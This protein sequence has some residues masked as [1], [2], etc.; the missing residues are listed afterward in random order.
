[1]FALLRV[2]PLGA[3]T[4]EAP[5]A[6]EPRPDP[7]AVEQA[8][9]ALKTGDWILKWEAMSQLARWKCKDAAGALKAILTGQDHPWVRGRALVALADL[10]GEEMLDQALAVSSNPSP[11][12][13]GAAADALGAIGSLRGEPAIVERLKDGDASVRHR[14]LV[15]FARLRGAAAWDTIAPR[16]ADPDPAV[17]RH[18]TQALVYIPTPAALGKMIELLAHKDKSVRIEASVSL[19]K[20]RAADAIPVLL[21]HM[22]KDGETDVRVACQTALAS[23]PPDVLAPPLVN[24]LRTEDVHL[25][26]AALKLLTLQPTLEAC[27]QVAALVRVPS[28]DYL[29]VLDDAFDLLASIQPDRYRSIFVLYLIHERADIRKRAIEALARCREGDLF[30]LLRGSL[31]DKEL[32]VRQA[33]F[34]ALRRCTQGAPREGIVDYL[35]PALQSK[36]GWTYQ[37]AIRLLGERITL[38]DLPKGLA[39]LDAFLGGSDTELRKLAAKALSQ[40]GPDES[41]REVARAQGFL[42]DWHLLGPFPNEAGRGFHVPYPPEQEVDLQ[43][44]YDGYFLSYGAAFGVTEAPCGGVRKRSLA[45]HPPWKDDA[46]GQVAATFLLDLPAAQELKL[47]MSLGL[48]DKA[49]ASDGAQLALSVD[50]AKLFE[51]VAR[52]DAWQP[53]EI[54]LSAYAGKKVALDLVAEPL[55]GPADDAVLVGEPKIVAGEKTVADLLALAPAALPR[56]VIPGK[57]QPLAWQPWRVN[58]IDGLVPLHDIFPPPTNQRLAYAVADLDS[59]DERT[60]RLWLDTD[61]GFILW[62]NGAKVAER[63][64]AG[65]Q[66][67][68]LKLRPGRNRLLIKVCN[69][70]DWWQFS[71]R[72]TEL[73]GRRL[74][75]PAPPPPAKPGKK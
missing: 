35:A 55:K 4:P 1:V 66:K 16:L 61:D 46:V 63:N 59:P 57:T 65:E 18:A 28:K 25:Y 40:A 56:A 7:L 75:S 19:S 22:A 34:D 26:P 62:H 17:V 21:E 31:T 49:A 23:F 70:R 6:A 67:L 9:D 64:A 27:D 52:K 50:K 3:A 68:D 44:Q 43:K 2:W 10:F 11:E 36:D 74:G 41:K 33:A 30:A 32:G 58:R 48:Q 29:N 69:N 24:A 42:T 71:V 15:A 20:V 73:D 45:L 51:Q 54:D 5:R 38:G 72:A 8:L 39:A 53:A 13:R 37:T 14:A 47:T 12:L 60:V